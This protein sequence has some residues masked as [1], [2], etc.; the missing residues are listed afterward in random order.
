MKRRTV[1]FCSFFLLLIT[2]LAPSSIKGQESNARGQKLNALPAPA[3]R[4]LVKRAVVL[5]E[6]DRPEQAIAALK[7]ALSLSPEY[8][9]AHIEYM[10]IK[11]NF[12]GRQDEVEKE[13]ENLIRRHPKNVVYLM[14]LYSNSNG[15]FGSQFLKR[16]AELAPAWAWGHYASA[17][18]TKKDDPE[19]AVVELELCIK[20]DGSA[21]EAYYL[22]IELQEQRL[23]KIDDAIRTAER[24]TAQTDI[25]PTLRLP[26]LW[27]LRLVKANQSEESKLA[28]RQ[29]LSDLANRTSEVDVLQAVRSAYEGL[30]ND[31]VSAK[32]IENRIRQ[33]DPTWTPERGVIFTKI[34]TNQS[35]VPR[36]VV[37]ANRQ[38]VINQQVRRIAGA[39]DSAPNQKIKQLRALLALGVRP[40]TR[41]IVFENIFQL[42]VRSSDAPLTIKYA[43]ILHHLDPEDSKLLSQTALALADN[44]TYLDLALKFATNAASLTLEFRP[45]KRPLNTSLSMLDQ[46]FPEKRQ[47]ERYRENRAEALDALG[48]VLVQLGRTHEGEPFLRQALQIEQTERR[49]SR[50]ATALVKLDRTADAA[51]IGEQARMFLAESIKK[52][53]VSES[54]DDLEF[55]SIEGDSLRLFNLKGRVV[56]VNFW[57]SWCIPCR[58]EI[59]HLKALF[60]KYRSQ[61]LAIVAISVDEDPDKA[62]AFAADNKLKFFVSIDPALGKRFAE[63]SIPVSLFIDRN[64]TIR[65]RKNGYEDGD[66][67]EIELVLTELLKG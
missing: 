62:R 21:R 3:A 57:A 44:K 38:I 7:R 42:A 34:N 41:R 2:S 9:R 48:W 10:N 51:A 14:A 27:R 67:R 46:I 16:V 40:E 58:Q 45:A 53:F 18:L 23:H 11:S 43:K 64:G 19:N 15:E 28:L 13:Y 20:A 55:K 54:V 17:L 61:G 47:R 39:I 1:C 49:L 35:G 65:Y 4:E 31:S 8:L 30:L 29:E 63:D 56:I 36:F 66:E 52:N 25:R 50:L 32:F 37:L 59:P 60:E 33:I 12:L 6:R 24:L 5:A 26:Q 22:L